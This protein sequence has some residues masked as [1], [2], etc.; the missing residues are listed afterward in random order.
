MNTRSPVVAKK[1][2]VHEEL[3]VAVLV[4]AFEA[5][6]VA[7]DAVHARRRIA[8]EFDPFRFQR[9]ELRMNHGARKRDG[10]PAGSIEAPGNQAALGSRI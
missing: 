8:R 7:P 6:T 5:A 3:I 10:M 4:K 9:M 2:F 1:G